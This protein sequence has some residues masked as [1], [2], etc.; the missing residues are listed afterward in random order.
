MSKRKALGRGLGALIQ[1]PEGMKGEYVNLPVEDIRPS[2]FQPRK[3][4]DSQRLIELAD[5]IK[6]KGVIEPILVRRIGSGYELIAGERRLR[7][8]RMAGVKD[9]PVLVM[10]VSDE[11]AQEIALVENIQREE[12]NP[13]EEAEAFKSLIEG[14]GLSQDEVARKVG[15]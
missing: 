2:R 5:S 10:D 4:F 8:A 14:F 3:N 12:L 1:G 9:V 13:L 7:A 15:K 11:D 6:E